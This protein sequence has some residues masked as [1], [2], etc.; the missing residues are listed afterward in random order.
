MHRVEDLADRKRP[1]PPASAGEVRSLVPLAEVLG[2]CLGRGPA[3]KTVARAHDALLEG[4]G[5]ELHVL[6]AAPLEDI[7][8]ASS[9]LVAEAISRLRGGRVIREAGYDGQYGRI[10]LFEE[11]EL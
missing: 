4:V 1:R 9:P 5:P 2:E 6:S 3:T 7:E 10:R 11:G 8:R